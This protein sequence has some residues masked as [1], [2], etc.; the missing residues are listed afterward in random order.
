MSTGSLWQPNKWGVHAQITGSWCL[1]YYDTREEAV[2]ALG[3]VVNNSHPSIWRIVS[4]DPRP[5]EVIVQERRE[6]NRQTLPNG[7][8]DWSDEGVWW[9]PTAGCG[10]LHTNGHWKRCTPCREEDE[11]MRAEGHEPAPN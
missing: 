5:V 7:D 11:R 3:T 6:W 4:P 10:R 2:A 8:I 1:G 9:C